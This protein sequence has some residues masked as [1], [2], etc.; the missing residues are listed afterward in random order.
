VYERRRISRHRFD[1]IVRRALRDLPPAFA[2]R[3]ENVDVVVRARPSA[4]QLEQAHL[5]PGHTL[6]GLYVGTDLTRRGDG[7]NFALPD[8]VFIFQQPLEG[9]AES[10]ADLI[11]RVRHTVLHE[12]A[13][14]FG[15]SDERLHEIDRY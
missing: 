7:Y 15:I 13:H 10:E 12:I 1:G 6:L 5:S 2:A 4:R 9:L 14:H 3:L 11:A 8:R